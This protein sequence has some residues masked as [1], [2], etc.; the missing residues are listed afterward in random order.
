MLNPASPLGAL[1]AAPVRPGRLVWIG[2]RPERRAPP[3]VVAQALAEAGRGLSG[4]HYSRRDGRRQ[5]TLIQAE[6]LAAVAAY[7]GREALD[8]ALVRRNLVVSGINL[9]ALKGR[10]VA[11]GGARLE[12]LDD[13]HPC[14]RMEEALGQ[15]GYN[16]M[17]GHGGVTAR[18]VAG[19]ALRVGDA[20]LRVDGDRD[21]A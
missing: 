19:G 5:A 16:A 7:L 6:H 4:D 1:F 9:L 2:L 12:I 18:V 3:A 8:P 17:R 21:G 14:S 15:G 11:I 10:V 13:C 20:V